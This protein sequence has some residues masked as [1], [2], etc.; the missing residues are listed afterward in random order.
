MLHSLERYL[1]KPS[2]N[3]PSLFNC[4]MAEVPYSFFLFNP[5]FILDCITFI[6]KRTQNKYH[7]G[8]I[9]SRNRTSNALIVYKHVLCLLS[10]PGANPGI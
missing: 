1:I 10:S 5:F 2:E 3:R 6:L 8:T 9:R 7:K 4:V